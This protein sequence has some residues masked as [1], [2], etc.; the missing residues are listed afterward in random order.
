MC[1]VYPRGNETDTSF[2]GMYG[3]CFLS[4]RQQADVTAM[5]A[6]HCKGS[7]CPTTTSPTWAPS[8]TRFFLLLESGPTYV[9]M[10]YS[11]CCRKKRVWYPKKLQQHDTLVNLYQDASSETSDVAFSVG[12][13]IY[14]AHKCILSLHGK[15]LYEI[16]NEY[17]NDMPIPIHSVRKEIFKSI[18]D[19][20][21]NVKTPE[22]ENEE[23][24]T[25]FLVAADCYDCPHLKLYAESIIVDKFLNTGN[26]AALLI[27]ADSHSCALLKEAAT[28]VFVTD[29]ET[30]QNAEAC[31]KSENR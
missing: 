22:I 7:V 14:R 16:A 13:T 20:I 28:N 6:W 30:V 15:K 5:V 24:A 26:A 27:F 4:L 23:I 21:Y 9:R 25:E 18:L 29:A 12:G 10:R 3:S 8:P 11:N 17:D 1:W 31:S 19:V 2:P